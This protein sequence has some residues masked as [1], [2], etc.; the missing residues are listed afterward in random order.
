MRIFHAKD[1]CSE[2]RAAPYSD[3]SNHWR[4]R[5]CL[6]SNN[7]VSTKEQRGVRLKA[8]SRSFR[9]AP[10]R[11]GSLRN[12]TT[13]TLR[14]EPIVTDN[15]S[16]TPWPGF[17]LG[18]IEIDNDGNPITNKILLSP[19]REECDFLKQTQR[20]WSELDRQPMES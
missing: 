19:P 18:K 4:T 20:W 8:S 1:S 6:V 15:Q 7:T 11:D 3:S 16:S 9:L 5:L 12:L 13:S 14:R 17:S 10:F 2:V